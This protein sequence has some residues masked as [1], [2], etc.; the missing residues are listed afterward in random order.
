MNPKETVF[1]HKVFGKE[2]KNGKIRM[3]KFE[4]REAK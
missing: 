1:L 2:E 4:I 3:T